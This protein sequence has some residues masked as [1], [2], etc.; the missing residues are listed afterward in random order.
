MKFRPKFKRQQKNHFGN[1]SDNKGTFLVNNNLLDKLVALVTDGAPFVASTKEGVIRKLKNL[2]P[3]LMGIHC[4][5]HRI[6][7]TLKDAVKAETKVRSL[8][9]TS[10]LLISFLR[11]TS[12]KHA[13]FQTE[14][15]EVAETRGRALELIQPFDVRWFTYHDAIKQLL[16]L[17]PFVCNTLSEHSKEGA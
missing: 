10:Y 1:W 8:H 11:E 3:Y 12:K 13:I 6:N 16:N 5:A 15:T 17:Y 4:M 7:L 14:L 9:E 2:K